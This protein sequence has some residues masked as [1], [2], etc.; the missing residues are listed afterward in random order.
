MKVRSLGMTAAPLRSP[1]PQAVTANPISNSSIIK[2]ELRTSTGLICLNTNL[3]SDLALLLLVLAPLTRISDVL[4]IKDVRVM[5][6][7]GDA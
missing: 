6:N 5:G 7:N 3:S 1:P 4:G 2:A